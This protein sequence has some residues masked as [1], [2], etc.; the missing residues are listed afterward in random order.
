MVYSQFCRQNLAAVQ[1][2]ASGFAMELWSLCVPNEFVGPLWRHRCAGV[3]RVAGLGESL[4]CL[5]PSSF[6]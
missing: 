5:F 4:P 2:C 6:P 1:V 3:C